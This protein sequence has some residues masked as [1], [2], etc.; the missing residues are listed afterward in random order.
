MLLEFAVTNYRSIRERQIM[1]FRADMN[2]GKKYLNDNLITPT[3][4]SHGGILINT[5]VVFGANAAGKSNFLKALHALELMVI[6][7]DTFK[8]DKPIST[9]EPF[10]LDKTSRQNP[11]VFE[12]EF[13]AKDGIRYRYEVAFSKNEIEREELY[14][15]QNERTTIRPALLFSRHQDLTLKFGTSYEGKRDFTFN[16]NQLV[17]GFV[18]VSHP[19]VVEAYRFFSKYL[20][21]APAQSIAFDEAM[22]KMAEEYLQRED[23]PARQAVKSLILASDTGISDIFLQKLGDEKFKFPDDM[24]DD[25]KQKIINRF[26]NRI[27]TVHP[28]YEKGEIIEEAIFDLSDESTGTIKL[29]GIAG[30]IVDALQDGSTIIVDELDKSLHP[31]LSRMLIEIFQNPELNPRH[32]QLV[33]S[34]H[35]VTLLD[36]DL[37]RRDQIYLIDKNTEGVSLMTRLSDFTGISKLIPIQ[38]WYMNGLFK[39]VPA[40]NPYAINLNFVA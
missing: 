26:R 18:G 38:K 12:V 19:S 28:I 40:I 1:S 33:F 27:K 24:P 22:L 25:E 15:Y 30:F 20:F 17:L 6:K 37:F 36:R 9:Y 8:L 10:K 23:N 34:T 4:K 31:I 21:Y 39:A 13:I 7:A 14:H 35:D 11:A 3:D 16:P 32:A 29:L 5:A 2:V